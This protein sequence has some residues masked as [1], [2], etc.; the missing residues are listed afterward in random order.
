MLGFGKKPVHYF[1]RGT[2]AT[3]RQKT[4]A[5]SS[6]VF[7]RKLY[8]LARLRRLDNFELQST[9]TQTLERW[10]DQPA[11]APAS[12]RWI[13]HRQVSLV[14]SWR[15]DA[16]SAVLPISSART[17]RLIFKEAVRGKSLS[18]IKQ[19]AM[20]LKSGKRRLRVL[21]SSSNNPVSHC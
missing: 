14:H 2:I 19:P 7:T 9:C 18:Q 15:M 8:G 16:R 3:D 20:R 12:G 17:V 11:T 5:S 1:V 13:H 4:P 10:P 6:I 21:T